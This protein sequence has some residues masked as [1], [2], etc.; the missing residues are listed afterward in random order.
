MPV[1]AALLMAGAVAALIHALGP[2]IENT[3]LVILAAGTG[4]TVYALCIAVMA[5]DLLRFVLELPRFLN[6]DSKGIPGAT[7]A[8]PATGA[9]GSA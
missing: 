5:R 8:Q 6:S 4:I 7:A 2:R 1:L 9:G 3:S